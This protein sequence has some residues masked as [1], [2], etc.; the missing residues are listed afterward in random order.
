MPKKW[1]GIVVATVMLGGA[2]RTFWHL[3]VGWRS[4]WEDVDPECC[5]K[6]RAGFLGQVDNDQDGFP[7]ATTK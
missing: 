6:A 1:I 2:M 3:F 5:R 4:C 7:V